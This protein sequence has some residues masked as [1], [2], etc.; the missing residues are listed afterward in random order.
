MNLAIALPPLRSILSVLLR[1]RLMPLLVIVQIALA[2]A[3]LTNALALLQRQLA[4]MLAPDG[5]ARSQLLLVDQLI[6]AQGRWQTAE[7]Q[8]TQQAL[9]AIPGVRAVAPTMGLP[10]RQSMTF[11]VTGKSPTG[12]SVT[13]TGFAGDGLVDTLG[14]ELVGGRDFTDDDYADTGPIFGEDNSNKVVPVIVTEALARRWFPKGGALG[15]YLQGDE[16]P[17]DDNAYVVVGVVRHLLRYQLSELDDGKAEYSLL[18]PSRKFTGLPI[19]AYAV[20]VDPEHRVAVSRAI[21]ALIE[22]RYAGRLMRGVPPVIN[23]YESLRNEA[24]K[25]RRAAVWLLGTVCAVVTVITLIGIASLSGYWIEQRV[26]QIGIRRALGATRA[27]ILA[28][29]QFE[30]VLLTLFGLTLGLPLALAINQLLMRYYE[31]PRLPLH[32]LPIGAGALLLIGQLAVFG[33]A[34]RAAAV[35]PAVAT[36]SA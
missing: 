11:E 15:G 36:R 5:I 18:Y 29:F 13:A 27:Q 2:C 4:P 19:M 34:R 31:L 16:G 26:R 35:P 21:T 24:F 22:H 8:A 10:M 9:R 23:D 33:P 28:H 1:H 17:K 6:L 25:P 32:W 20:R 14:L 7:V 3:I 12:V 30:N